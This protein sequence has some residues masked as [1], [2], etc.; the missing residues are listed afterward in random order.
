VAT[1][2][3]A[4]L[5]DLTTF[6]LITNLA[7][8]GSRRAQDSELTVASVEE[9]VR[10]YGLR[11]WVEQSYK[12]VKHA[13]GWSDYQVRSD[14]AI[15]RH[16]QLVCCAF[17]FCW[18]YQAH[19]PAQTPLTAPVQPPSS[20][21]KEPKETLAEQR[22]E[23]KKG[24]RNVSTTTGELAQ[25]PTRGQSLARTLGLAPAILAGVVATA[26]ASPAPTAS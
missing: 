6:Y 18:Y 19:A 10:L 9:V 23:G 7:A 16:W 4:T 26:P 17:S 11:M 1:T 21:Q 20:V 12:Q 22:A 25:S 2:D 5:P 24:A 13:L 8:P 14:Q 3:P 15:R